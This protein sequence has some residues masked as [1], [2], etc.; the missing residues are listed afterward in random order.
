MER[1]VLFGRYRLLSRAGAGGSAQVWR[2]EDERTGEE[3]AVKRLHPVVFADPA[4]RRRLERES[5][6]LQELDSPNI[7]RIRDS[8]VTADEAALV[9]DYVPGVSLGQRLAEQGRLAVAEAIG[10]VEDVAAALGTAHGA[11][12]VHRD[13]KPANIILAEDGRA[14][15]TDFG[16]AR[17]DEAEGASGTL[18]AVTDPGMVVGSLRYM[19]PEQLRG[20]P[21]TPASDQYG[22]A[23]VAYEM[24]SGRPPYGAGTPV[25]LA[26]AQ[27]EPPAPLAGIE[28]ALADAIERGLAPDP[29]DRF[30]DVAGFA[31]AVAAALRPV[32]AAAPTTVV[33]AVAEAPAP[34]PPAPV[35]ADRTNRNAIAAGALAVGIAAVVA[36]AALDRGTPT[37]TPAEQPL[38]S[39][40]VAPASP[41][42]ATPAATAAPADQG[43]DGGAAKGKGKAGGNGKD[44][45]GGRGKD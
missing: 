24:L 42:E 23:A 13:V 36:L 43:N 34:A 11:S 8:H 12:V 10:V 15:L 18:T 30:P 28:P 4:A 16:V 35:A 7:V 26:A 33:P 41:P 2:A 6:A 44:K 32:D 5:R 38:A 27:A 25:A 14:L 39:A 31:A 22:L 1:S 21:A 20:E 9:L 29:A 17:Q 3:V 45:G 19:S 37:S 40:A